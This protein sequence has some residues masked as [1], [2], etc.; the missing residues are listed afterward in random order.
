MLRKK[1]SLLTLI[2][3]I[4]YL[5]GCSSIEVVELNDSNIEEFSDS[6]IVAVVTKDNKIYE[7]ETSG[8]K[9]KPQIADSV[10]KGWVIGEQFRDAYK[11]Y[12]MKLQISEL[13]TLQIKETDATKTLLLMGAVIGV[14]IAILALTFDIHMNL[15]DVKWRGM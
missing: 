2:C 15:G 5:Y 9:P 12:E 10:L 14:L 13:K 11:I 6:D 8:V 3:F 7:F 4:T 1:I